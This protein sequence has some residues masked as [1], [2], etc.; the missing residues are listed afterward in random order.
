[1][2]SIQLNPLNLDSFEILVTLLKTG[3]ILSIYPNETTPVPH[4]GYIYCII[5]EQDN[6]FESPHFH[7]KL[8]CTI[9]A[10]WTCP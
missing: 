6:P 1:M 5:N 2:Y 9:Q 3:G 8:I 7:K 10:G 4:F